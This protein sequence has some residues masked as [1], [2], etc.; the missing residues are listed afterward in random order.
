VSGRRFLQHEIGQAQLQYSQ[1]WRIEWHD[2]ISDENPRV[3][4]N[5]GNGLIKEHTTTE[6]V[7][8]K[9]AKLALQQY[10]DNSP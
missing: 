8:Y 5:N 3:S 1:L 9:K 2:P 6:E 4:H 7:E 10:A